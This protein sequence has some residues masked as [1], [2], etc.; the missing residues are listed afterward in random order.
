MDA[1]NSPS[2]PHPK[3]TDEAGAV[4]TVSTATVPPEAAVGPPPMMD[5][6]GRESVQMHHELHWTGCM[7]RGCLVH[8]SAKEGANFFPEDSRTAQRAQKPQKPQKPQDKANKKARQ[9]K[10]GQEVF[11]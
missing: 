8:M 9:P 3:T 4:A 2:P 10:G 7:I 6:Q 5:E 1:T 11:W